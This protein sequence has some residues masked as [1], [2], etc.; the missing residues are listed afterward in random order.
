MRI[1]RVGARLA[2]LGGAAALV[3]SSGIVASAADFPMV[4]KN[5]DVTSQ[6]KSPVRDDAIPTVAVDPNDSQRVVVAEGDFRTGACRLHVSTDGGA[7][8]AVAKRSPLPPQFEFCTPGQGFMSFS[9]AWSKSGTLFMAI[10]PWSNETTRA[11]RS[12][13]VS[14]TSDLGQTWESVLVQDNRGSKPPLGASQAHVAV[15]DAHHRV[16]LAWN[17]ST[18]VQGLPRPVGRPYVAISTDGGQTFGQPKDVSDTSNPLTKYLSAGRVTMTVAPDGTIVVVYQQFSAPKAAPPEAQALKPALIAAR[19]SDGGKTWRYSIVERTTDFTSYPEIAA[20]ANPGGSGYRLVVVFEDLADGA[21]GQMQIRDIF[22]SSSSDGGS[23]WTP[24]H[25]VT[26][27]DL[28]KDLANKYVPGISAAPNGRVDV[29]WYDTRNDNGSL[30][31]DT[32]YSYSTDGGRTWAPNIRVSDRPS[33]RHYGQFANYSD[34]RG[35][36]G[37]ASDDHV[38]YVAWDDT[39]NANSRLDVQDVYFAAV[40]LSPLPTSTGFTALRILGAVAGGLVV[41]AVLLGGAGLFIRRRRAVS[42]A[43]SPAR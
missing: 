22:A 37:I 11:R 5:V 17:Q 25:R 42:P 41:T 20:A 12:V 14:R 1:M 10:T 7:S 39:R 21:A 23:T 19:S 32:Y 35:P 40:Q 13:V 2:L 31:T 6:D 28:S 26:D 30:L 36:V 33:N 43:A 29:A 34:V 16:V 18:V 24:R 4:T 27:D 8:F 9:M 38:A 3:M 15:D